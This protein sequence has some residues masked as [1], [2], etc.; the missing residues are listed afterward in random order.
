MHHGRHRSPAYHQ[1]VI[2]PSHGGPYSDDYNRSFNRRGPPPKH[3]LP[4]PPPAPAP[5]RRA[6]VFLEAGRLAAEYL[7]SKGLLPPDSLPP[8]G[9]PPMV[10][11]LRGD[12]RENAFVEGRTSALARLGGAVPDAGPLLGRRRYNEDFSGP[13]NNYRARRR[14]G[15]YRGHYGSDLGR[16]NGRNRGFDDAMDGEDDFMHAGYRGDHRGG[17]GGEY[18]NSGGRRSAFESSAAPLKSGLESDLENFEFPDDS[19]PKA[20]SDVELNKGL[21]EKS[22][23]ADVETVEEDREGDGL[24]DENGGNM[25]TGKEVVKDVVEPIGEEQGGSLLKLCGFMKVPTRARSSLM[26]KPL[27]SKTDQTPAKEPMNSME[28]VVEVS[29]SD[30]K[31]G[32][33]NVESSNASSEE[34]SDPCKPI[35]VESSEQCITQDDVNEKPIDEDC[36]IHCVSEVMQMTSAEEVMADVEGPG[37]ANE[38]PRVETKDDPKLGEEKQEFMVASFKICDLNLMDAPDITEVPDEDPVMEEAGKE[39][40]LDVGLSM[41]GNGSSIDSDNVEE[42]KLIQVIDLEVE[43]NPCDSSNEKGQ[44][45]YPS[46][47]SFLNQQ[48]N[49]D[50]LPEIQDGYGLTI[51]EFFGSDIGNCSSVQADINNLQTGMTL[52]GGQVAP[53]VDDSLYIS[54]GELPLNYMDMEV[55]D[56]PSLGY[57]NHPSLEYEKFF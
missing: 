45:M 42:D 34:V 55:W 3:Y 6:D 26:H 7:V 28:E 32:V 57:E 18:I 56:H 52:H 2:G 9:G 1:T 35:G 30:P 54:L 23:S 4:P 15:P 25:E 20:A 39:A 38:S 24:I 27:K 29:T 47:E 51:P 17:G 41:A 46:I 5:S 33:V 53:G 44:L 36:H 8:R 50:G 13:R 49:P 10:R 31:T 37:D 16:E 40:L 43:D 48:V 12:D 11:D 14:S 21:I 22:E 19:G